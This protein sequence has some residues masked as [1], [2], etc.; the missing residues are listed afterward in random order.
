MTQHYSS[1]DVAR[2]LAVSPARLRAYARAGLV[3][4]ERGPRG[5]YRYTFQDLA[6][7]RAAEGLADAN[8]SPRRMLRALRRLKDRLPQG[9]PL[10]GVRLSVVG[11]EVVARDG[12]PAW[13]AE[14]GQA[15]FEFDMQKLP[16]TIAAHGRGQRHPG[17][18]T[19]REPDAADWYELGTEIESATP[20]HGR[21]AYRR[22]LELE[23]RHLGA[24]VRLARLLEGAGRHR[25]A[26]AHYRLALTIAPRE[27][28]VLLDLS[29]CLEQQGR[30]AHALSACLEA[31]E[32]DPNGAEARLSAARLCERIGDS[33]AALRHLEAYRDLERS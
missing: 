31:I 2:L 23:P 27:P 19:P 17:R 13:C 10:S 6:V 7:L 15:R 12:G 18:P 4:P 32:A 5:E 14:S 21:D 25:A 22:A 28:A 1:R 9:E 16:A 3:S 20:D 33:A 30:I 29:S 26:E 24:R 8:V 11:D